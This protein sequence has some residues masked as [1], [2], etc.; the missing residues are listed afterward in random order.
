MWSNVTSTNGLKNQNRITIESRDVFNLNVTS[1]LKDLYYIVKDNWMQD[2]YKDTASGTKQLATTTGY[3]RRAPFIPFELKND[4]GSVL[5]F[6]TLISEMDK[7]LRN[8]DYMQPNE[9]WVKVAPGETV[10]FSFKA[11]DKL[12]HRDSHKMKMHQLGVKI[13]GWQPITPVTVDQVGV[14]FRH[15]ASEIHYRVC[16]CVFF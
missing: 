11:R 3:R 1:T 8:R 5:F 2:L 6:T 14:Y 15:A 13:E 4:T 16:F 7:S 12:R 9:R 10:P